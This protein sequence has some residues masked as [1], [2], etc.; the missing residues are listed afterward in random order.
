M[1]LLSDRQL[2][3]RMGLPEADPMRLEIRP[4]SETVSEPGLVG[5]GLSSFGYDIRL[6]EKYTVFS[7]M[8]G[9]IVDPL[10]LRAELDERRKRNEYIDVRGDKC[11]IPPNSFVLAES[12]EYIRV[13]EDCLALVLGKSTYARCAINLNMTPL[14]P[15]WQGIITLE[16][17]NM[18][19]LPAVVH[20]RMGIGQ[21]IFLR[22][23]EPCEVPY[24]KKK[25]PRYQNQVGMTPPNVG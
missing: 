3:L 15:G 16:I 21:V 10:T 6:G 18:S 11:T 13:P 24:N 1:G 2:K 7:N 12:L 14:E 9:T 4:Y 19:P 22:G 5:F 8:F 23:D 25:N 20:S 17:A